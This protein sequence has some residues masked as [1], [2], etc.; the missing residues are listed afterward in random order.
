MSKKSTVSDEV[1]IS[2]LMQNGTIR[3]AASAAGIAERTIYDRM[4]DR[5]FRS[6]YMAAKT[7]I[8]RAAV[9]TINGK[10]SEAVET[11]AEIMHDPNTNN[12]VRLQ[13]AQTII[14]N[15]AKFAQRLQREEYESREEAKDP[16]SFDFG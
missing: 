2:A 1:I 12:A 13:A 8:V 9:F 11:V 15:A 6:E 10:L 14:N 5:E 7:D 16:F 4:K 3:E